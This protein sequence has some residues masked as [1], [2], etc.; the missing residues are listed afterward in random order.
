VLWGSGVDRD[1]PSYQGT[2]RPWLNGASL[3]NDAD[4]A[5]LWCTPIPYA[6]ALP[7]DWLVT[8]DH[9]GRDEVLD[10]GL[11]YVRGSRETD[12]DFGRRS[13]QVIR[14]RGGSSNA[15]GWFS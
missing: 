13:Y 10:K 15:S 2:R 8:P 7:G 5:K 4:G 6:Q 12:R 3:L 1:Q 14:P 9:A 11:A